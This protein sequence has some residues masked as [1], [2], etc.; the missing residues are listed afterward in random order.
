M[1]PP[2]LAGASVVIVGA[3]QG[4]GAAVAEALAAKRAR[5]VLASRSADRLDAVAQRCA[6][7]G[8]ASV[9]TVTVDVR[10]PDSIE[11]LREAVIDRHGAPRV[12]VNSAGTT[13]S[14][15]A[16]DL[17]VEE[18][19]AI[20][21][22]HLR[23][24]FLTAR[25]FAPSMAAEGYGKIVNLSSTW[26]ATVAPGRSAYCAAKAGLSHLT[27]ALAVEW[28]EL[29]IRVN[30]VAPTATRTPSRLAR[31]ASQPQLEGSLRERIPM[32]RLA[33]PADVVGAVLFLAGT[34]SDFVTGHTLY[35][36]GGWRFSR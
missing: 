21:D 18:W 16:L 34:E 23:G 7:A 10:S 29:G 17:T 12:L 28:A 4:I 2:D 6:S 31:F 25:A 32:G 33:E 8:A 30:A 3:S 5:V 15:S 24:P 27:A 14:K 11:S 19:D 9:D 22:V 20:Q 26:A 13:S 1:T 36:D 35:V